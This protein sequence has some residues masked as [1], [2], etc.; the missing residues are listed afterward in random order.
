MTKRFCLLSWLGLV[1]YII[2][3][4]LISNAFIEDADAVFLVFLVIASSFLAAGVYGWH[5]LI[6]RKKWGEPGSWTKYAIGL[7]IISP[8]LFILALVK[9][10]KYLAFFSISVII[11]GFSIFMANKKYEDLA[12]QQPAAEITP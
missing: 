5:C 6:N 2:S 7:L 4:C 10:D 11:I 9:D 3:T 1:V 8:I 12:S